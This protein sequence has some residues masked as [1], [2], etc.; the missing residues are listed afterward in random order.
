MDIC[1][2]V[3]ICSVLSDLYRNLIT[4]LLGR[5]QSFSCGVECRRKVLMLVFE[6]D[7]WTRR[8]DSAVLRQHCMHL[9]QCLA[10]LFSALVQAR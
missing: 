1:I 5:L 10:A 6:V 2:Y 7:S 4:L 3:L 8:H 9:Q